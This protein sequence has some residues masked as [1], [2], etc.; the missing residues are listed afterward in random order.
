M[1][2]TYDQENAARAAFDEN[3]T[4]G[5]RR[6]SRLTGCTP[7][8]A[9]AWLKRQRR[10]G[11]EGAASVATATTSLPEGQEAPAPKSARD[12]GVT[13]IPIAEFKGR[14]DYEG[15]LRETI[16]KLCKSSFVADVDI[17]A[18]CGIPIPAF[19]T[20]ASL[21]EFVACQI[22]D[23][24]TVFWSTKEN[25]DEVRSAARKWGVTK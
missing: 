3:P 10:G 2:L 11:G 6:L 7:S 22:K 1:A 21:P 15:M 16:A 18:R 5:W 19:R 13:G 23:A 25:A 20:V 8:S 4:I 17:R 12:A 9:E 14:F 24:G